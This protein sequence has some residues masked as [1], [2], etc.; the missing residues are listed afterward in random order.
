MAE[1]SGWDVEYTVNN[2]VADPD[3]SVIRGSLARIFNCL[4]KPLASHSDTRWLLE[5]NIS[6]A[7]AFAGQLL[8]KMDLRDI[9]HLGNPD[10]RHA[11]ELLTNLTIP[12]TKAPALWLEGI[13]FV[14]E[15]PAHLRLECRL[16]SVT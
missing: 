9:S 4:P 8:V 15:S 12:K 10:L 5:V 13:Q 6:D 3:T 2:V 1:V 14:Q 7:P 16:R 11:K